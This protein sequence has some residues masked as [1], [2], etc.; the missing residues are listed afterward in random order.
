MGFRIGLVGDFSSGAGSSRFLD[1][2]RDELGGIFRRTA[3]R[4]ELDLDFCSSPPL[5]LSLTE[6][7]QLHP[8]GLVTRVPELSRLLEAREAVGEPRRMRQLLAASGAPPE[9]AAEP[10]ADA[11]GQKETSG[12]DLLDAMLDGRDLS[13]RPSVQAPSADPAFDR[14]VAEIVGDAADRTDYARQDRWR[15]AVDAELARRVASI[16]GHPR[17]QELEAAWRSLHALVMRSQTGEPLRL[18]MLDLPAASLRDGSGTALLRRLW[19]DQ[20]AGVPGGDPFDLLVLDAAFTAAPEDRRALAELCTL[21]DAGGAPCLASL[22]PA[23][24]GESIDWDGITALARELR[25]VAGAQHLGL[26]APRVL[27]RP[28]YGPESDPAERFAFDQSAQAPAACL[29]GG[30]AWAVAEAVVTALAA[31]GRAADTARFAHLE[32]RPLHVHR[33][34]GEVVTSGPTERVLTDAEIERLGGLGMIA[35]SGL[36]G[37]DVIRL[38]SLRSVAGTPLF[39]D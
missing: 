22:S 1:V 35:L 38:A 11:P 27:L 25:G 16:L 3:P 10:A 28:P 32:G 21:A 34:D 8:D 2:D 17:F 14:M 12:R 6:W 4:L 15:Q 9:V 18:G 23:L 37:G 30:G 31:T 7:E 24:L 13:G 36:R 26:A 33:R 29:W 5:T 39:G 20:E 19:I